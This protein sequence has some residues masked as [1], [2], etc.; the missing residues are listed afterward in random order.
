VLLRGARSSLKDTKMRDKLGIFGAVAAAGLTL[1][2]A[3]SACGGG[4]VQGAQAQAVSSP[5]C[6]VQTGSFQLVVT[7]F[8]AD[9]VGTALYKF[10][11]CAK[12]ALIFLP[13]LAGP[14]N[15]TTFSASP[16]P[17]FLIPATIAWQEAGAH[18]FDNGVEHADISVVIT[19]GSNVM[20]FGHNGEM[21]GWTPSG[22]KGVGLQVITVFLD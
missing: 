9:T 11:P 16:L 12:Y 14:S 17:D 20:N 10:F 6:T 2:A 18:G 21:S 5:D 13:A 7:G 4:I 19:T 1:G 8:S 22:S 3:L 15:A